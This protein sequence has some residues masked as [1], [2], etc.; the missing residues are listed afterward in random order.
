MAIRKES[1]LRQQSLMGV[2]GQMITAARTAPKAKGK[3][4]LEI[5]VIDGQEKDALAEKM[6]ALAKREAVVFFSRDAD[7]LRNAGA[8]VLIGTRIRSLG[9]AFCGLCGYKNCEEK[10]KHPN[11][12]CIFNTSDL[13]IAVGSA[14]A[15]AADHRVDNRIM[16]TA[17]MA[18]LELGFF[19]SDVAI[20]LGIPLSISG[21]NPFFDRK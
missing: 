10:N 6:D 16:Y 3:D 4:N 18:A 15:V 7:N 13:G 5:I 1:E 21:K 17:G 9:L 8:I 12:P 11:T 2:A 20:A 14:A 19:S